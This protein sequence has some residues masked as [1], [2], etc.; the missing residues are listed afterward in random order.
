MGEI[1][2]LATQKAIEGVEPSPTWGQLP[3]AEAQVPLAHSV[4]VVAQLSQGLWHQLDTVVHPSQVGAFDLAG[5]HAD[6]EG[7]PG[8]KVGRCSCLEC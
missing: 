3:V 6:L 4:G 5:L 8:D 1:S 7:V 2:L